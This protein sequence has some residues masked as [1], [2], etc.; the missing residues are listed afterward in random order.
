MTYLLGKDIALKIKEQI[1]ENVNKIDEKINLTILL[2]KN[3]D[4]SRGYVNSLK[5]NGFSLG[6]DVNVIEMNDDQNEYILKIQELNNND[7][8]HGIMV[9]R[10][11]F[12]NANE[13]YIL[14]FI[15]P[16]KDVDVNNKL[17]LG[18]IFIGNDEI[19][20]ATAKAILKMLEYYNIELSGKNVLV[21][22]R[23]ISVGKPL[24]MMLLNKNATVTIAHSKTKDLMK[25][26]KD[27]DI[28]CCA[29]GKPHFLDA[30][31]ANENAI[32]IDAGIHYL[33]NKI[34]GDVLESDKVKMISK[35]PGGVGTI[36][37]SVLFDNLLKL[38]KKQRG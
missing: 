14:S 19:A 3:D 27:Y 35:V 21:I 33:E 25:K 1:K 29:V 11:L 12:K 17:S 30:S 26:I 4:S 36:T 10:P 38:Y 18:E 23:S 8:V 20:P 2:N 5:K 24:S 13:N 7:C 16:L 9:T 15:S 31:L 22:G 32:I 28:I 6:I 37:T 34:V